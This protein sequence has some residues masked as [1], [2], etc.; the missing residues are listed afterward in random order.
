MSTDTRLQALR[1]KGATLAELEPELKRAGLWDDRLPDALE[2]CDGEEDKARTLLGLI[3][4]EVDPETVEAVED[5][6]RQCYH[7]PSHSEQ[8]M[9][10]ANALM[11]CH[12]VEAVEDHDAGEGGIV[13]TYVN[14]GDTY[15][16]T[17]IHDEREGSYHFTSWGD[18]YENWENEQ[19]IEEE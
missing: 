6:I 8:V 14:T 9:C 13:M 10:A 15:A 11:E 19:V 7:R 12:G 1:R 18:W 16:L 17:L 5:W 4:G 3:D 2:L